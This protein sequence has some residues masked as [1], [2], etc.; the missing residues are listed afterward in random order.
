MQ[1][2][3]REMAEMKKKIRSK[4]LKHDDKIKLKP[5]IK[6]KIIPICQ[7]GNV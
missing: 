4:M 1:E 2:N 7:N 5:H 6:K 3:E